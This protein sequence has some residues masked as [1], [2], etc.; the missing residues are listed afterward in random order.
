M[1][2]KGY[3]WVKQ[4]AIKRNKKGRPMGGMIMGIGE[5]IE[6]KEEEGSEEKEG[7]VVRKVSLGKD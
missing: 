6:M 4:M 3:V 1:L 2:P 7:I 5:G